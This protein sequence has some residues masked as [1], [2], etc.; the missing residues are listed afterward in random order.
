MEADEAA[1]FLAASWGSSAGDRR[2]RFFVAMAEFYASCEVLALL[3]EREG[4]IAG[5]RELLGP[6]DPS[7]G[8]AAA[9][10]SVRA[11]WGSNKQANAAHGADS[12]AAA[13]R[14][15]GFVFGDGWAPAPGG[16]RGAPL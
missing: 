2:R 3:L 16:A 6:G 1:A 13:A 7:V 11:R 14:E 4:A 5:W 12:A 10:A 15:I 9:P 8:R